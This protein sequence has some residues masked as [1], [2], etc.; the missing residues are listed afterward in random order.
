MEHNVQISV[1]KN[2]SNNGILSCRVIPIKNQIL[3]AIIGDVDKMTVII[4]G[5]TVKNITIS[6]IK[7]RESKPTCHQ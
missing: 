4:L 5:D 2:P 3:R 6:E 1:S 7:E